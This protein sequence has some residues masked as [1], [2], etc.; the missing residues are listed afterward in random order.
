MSGSTFSLKTIYDAI[1]EQM[2][3]IKGKEFKSKHILLKDKLGNEYLVSQIKSSKL[4]KERSHRLLLLLS[5]R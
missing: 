4:H 3:A 5:N 1:N 2:I